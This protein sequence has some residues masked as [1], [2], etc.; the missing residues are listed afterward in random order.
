M[1]IKAIKEGWKNLKREDSK[2]ESIAIKRVKKMNNCRHF[3][4]EPNRLLR[5]KDERIPALS[6]MCC[7]SCGC[8]MPLKARQ[9]IEQCKCW[10]E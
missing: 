7:E 9:N 1:N 4:K 8:E 6:G 10:R 3:K 5:V 2:V